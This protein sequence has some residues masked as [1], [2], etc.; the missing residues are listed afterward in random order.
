MSRIVDDV[1]LSSCQDP[2]PRVVELRS[3]AKIVGHSAD[4][5]AIKGHSKLRFELSYCRVRTGRQ[6]PHFPEMELMLPRHD[7]VNCCP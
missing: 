1:V 2:R 7:T 3:W 6:R 5:V 4:G